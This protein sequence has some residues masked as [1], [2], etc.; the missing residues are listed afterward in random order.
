MFKK[1][2]ALIIKINAHPLISQSLLYFL[3]LV[4]KGITARPRG[5]LLSVPKI[6]SV[7][8]NSVS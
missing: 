3:V 7:S 2:R 1:W 6:N 8:Q 5:T 4:Q